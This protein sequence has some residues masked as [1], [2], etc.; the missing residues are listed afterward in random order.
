MGKDDVVKSS[1]VSG[2]AFCARTRGRGR[3]G[4]RFPCVNM[5]GM[6]LHVVL[7]VSVHIVERS[8]CIV[9]G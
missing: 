9:A 7:S 1:L 3:E 4:R 8:R 6:K 2:L 5:L